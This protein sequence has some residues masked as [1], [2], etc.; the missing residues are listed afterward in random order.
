MPR[1]SEHKIGTIGLLLAVLGLTS[2]RAVTQPTSRQ[3][4]GAS[5][6]ESRTVGCVWPAGE[7]KGCCCIMVSVTDFNG[8]VVTNVPAC[9]VLTR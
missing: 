2:G 1:P 8:S 4:A 7:V 9:C 6:R 5:C 3:S